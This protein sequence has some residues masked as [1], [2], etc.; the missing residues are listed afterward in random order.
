[1]LLYKRTTRQIVQSINQLSQESI[2]SLLHML[3]SVYGVELG[4]EDEVDYFLNEVTDINND[5]R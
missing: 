3:G 4:T 5:K 2:V 1:M